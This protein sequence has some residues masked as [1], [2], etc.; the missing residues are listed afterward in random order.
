MRN[1]FSS[2]RLYSWIRLTWESK[3]VSGSTDMPD[4]DLSQSALSQHLAKLR[5]EGLVT[6]RRQAQTIYYRLSS[7]PAQRI[8]SSLH[9][10]YCGSAANA[11]RS[12][13]PSRQRT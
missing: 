9:D 12:R 7:G 4:V 2:C 3:I 11:G 6:T 5:D 1:A 13:R 8:I 10:I